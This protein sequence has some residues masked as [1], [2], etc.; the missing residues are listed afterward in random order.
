[1]LKVRKNWKSSG[2]M[3]SLNVCIPY[4]Y[5]VKMVW[6]L[7]TYVVMI[8]MDDEYENNKFGLEM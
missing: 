5:C 8:L 3:E 6:M 7:P 4:E 2:L 1:M